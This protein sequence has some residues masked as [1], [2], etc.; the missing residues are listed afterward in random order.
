MAYCSSVQF[1]L[2]SI[3]GSLSPNPFPAIRLLAIPLEM[4]YCTVALARLS[5]SSK[6]YLSV[7]RLSVC[8][9]TKISIFGLALS[10]PT[11]LSSSNAPSLVMFALLYSKV[12]S[13]S[14][15]SVSVIFT[16]IGARGAATVTFPSPKER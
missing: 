15:T 10:T 8:A 6:L 13:L 16:S 14:T 11:N 9:L 3:L 4:T 5:E 1:S 2:Q 12:I 7:P